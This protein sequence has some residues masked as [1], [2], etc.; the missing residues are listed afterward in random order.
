MPIIEPDLSEVQSN[1]IEP[2]TYPAKVEA[3]DAGTSGAG[4]PKIVAHLEIEAG[5]RTFKRQAH[6]VISGKGAFNYES[7]MRACHFG[8]YIDQ[9][10]AGNKV[11]FDTDQLV[12][13]KLNVVIEAD[14]YNGQPSDK[15][16]SFLP[17]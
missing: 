13:Q 2:G 14:M 16:K 8:D 9:V 15:I 17:A 5:S 4:N 7:F 12:G 11:G 10:K 3:V 6:M 1:V